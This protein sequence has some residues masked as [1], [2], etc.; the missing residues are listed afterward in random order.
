AVTLLHLRLPVLE[1]LRAPFREQRL[2]GSLRRLG[3]RGG[4]RRRRRLD[5]AEGLNDVPAEARVDRCRDLT[6]CQGKRDLLE[7]RVEGAL[8]VRVLAAGRLRAR[9]GRVPPHERREL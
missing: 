2:P 6:C 1:L 7:G 3:E 5:R 4:V 9:I 8:G